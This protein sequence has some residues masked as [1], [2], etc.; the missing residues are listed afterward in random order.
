MTVIEK[1]TASA[2]EQMTDEQKVAAMQQ[3]MF[4]NDDNVIDDSTKT[5]EQLLPIF[6]LLACVDRAAA[7][8]IAELT[9]DSD[10]SV[11]QTINEAIT[12]AL[13]QS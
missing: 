10:N 7:I 1:K 13:L 4:V 11:V 9:D 8:C 5:A 3:F 6:H 12:T 2:Y